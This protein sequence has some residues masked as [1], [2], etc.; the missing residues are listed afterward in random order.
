MIGA[1]VRGVCLV[2]VGALLAATCRAPM[3]RF[4]GA[5]TPPRDPLRQSPPEGGTGAGAHASVRDSGSTP[6]RVEGRRRSTPGRAEAGAPGSP[7]G[8]IEW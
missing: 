2:G 1:N 3:G 8:V 5:R 4:E 7:P 6:P